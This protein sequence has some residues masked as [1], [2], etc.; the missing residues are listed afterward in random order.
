MNQREKRLAI[1]TGLVLG[2]AFMF[3]QVLEPAWKRHEEQQEQRELVESALERERMLSSR[4]KTL[5]KRRQELEASLSPGEGESL[6]PW[7]MGH[8]RELAQAAGFQPSSL[9][10]VSA[11]PL[12]GPAA[13]DAGPWTELKLELRVKTSAKELQEFLIRLAASERHL[14]VRALSMTPDKKG[15][16]VETTI[17]LLALAPREAVR[18]LGG[19]AQ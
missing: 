8:V 18:G 5:I 14:R 6:L 13:K 15:D 19:E 4:I 11:Q 3:L 2:G 7:L 12:D 16:Q 1:A 17:L 10:F 9:R